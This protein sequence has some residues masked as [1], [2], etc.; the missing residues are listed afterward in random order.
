MSTVNLI[1]DLTAAGK[2]T[3][4]PRGDTQEDTGIRSFQFGVV[5]T[6]ALAAVVRV[7]GMNDGRFP[8]LVMTST[9]SGSDMVTDAEQDDFQ[10]EY[11]QA[12]VVSLSGTGARVTVIMGG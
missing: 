1:T 12:E 10:W 2:G 11:Y 9:L 7:Y 6:G 5:G 4:V 3:L 8:T